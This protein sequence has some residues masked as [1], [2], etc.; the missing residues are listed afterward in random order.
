[1]NGRNWYQDSREAVKVLYGKDWK[2]FCGLLAATSPNASVKANVTL[3][4]KAFMQIKDTGTITREGYIRTH[5]MSILAVLKHKRPNG[6]KCHDLYQN[7]IGN[8]QFVPVD[9]WMVRYAGLDKKSPSKFDYDYIEDRVREEAEDMGITPAQR[10]AEIWSAIRG[11]SESYADVL[12]QF[13]L[14]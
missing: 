9:I 4:R 2:L 1:M 7:L 11:S 14:C 6:R 12:I 13:N 10:Q 5:Y 3:A 8:E